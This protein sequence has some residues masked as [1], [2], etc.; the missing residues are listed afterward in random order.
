MGLLLLKHQKLIY[1]I[2]VVLPD[3]PI[4]LQVIFG[5][6]LQVP[7]GQKKKLTSEGESLIYQDHTLQVCT[8]KL[9]KKDKSK[10]E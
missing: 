6:S 7:R 4:Y 3:I 2:I 10:S 9:E 8:Q 1:N 5:I